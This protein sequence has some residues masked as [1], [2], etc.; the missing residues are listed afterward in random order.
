MAFTVSVNV[1]R[2][3]E[4]ACDVASAFA[5]VSDVPKSVSHLPKVERLTDLGG[6]A[7]R[8]ETEKIGVEKYSLQTIYASQ[9]THDAKKKTVTWTPIRGEGNALV[10]GSWEVTAT[11]DGKTRLHL[12][13]RG[14]M[15]FPFPALVKAL[16]TPFVTREFEG[17]IAQYLKNLTRTL[18]SGGAAKAP[19]KG[20]KK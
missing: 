5:L 6:G 17:L 12:V 14:E 18:E 10:S 11:A 1:D 4:V 19:K 20:A 13:N 8:L 15:Q 2:S 7:Y 9:Y 3:I 16:V